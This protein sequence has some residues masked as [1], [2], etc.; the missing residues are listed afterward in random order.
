VL[1]IVFDLKGGSVLLIACFCFGRGIRV[2]NR[3]LFWE[4]D[5]CFSC[6]VFVLGGESVLPIVLGG[7]SVLLIFFFGR[8]SHLFIVF[9]VL[10]GGSCCLWFFALGGGSVLLI[11]FCF[12]RGI[13]VAHRFLFWQVDPCCSCFFCFGRGV[14][15]AHDFLFWERIRAAHRFFF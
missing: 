10:G 3:F 4:K 2:A 14:R 5:P 6:F 8:G 9:F 13:R 7:G 15:V 12:V 1:L 11:V